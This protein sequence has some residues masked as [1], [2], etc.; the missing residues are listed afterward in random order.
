MT[1]L[2]LF[3]Y[4]TPPFKEENGRKTEEEE[5][6]EGEEEEEGE[7]V[8]GEEEEEG[9][10]EGEEEEGEKEGEEGEEMIE[11][12]DVFKTV[13]YNFSFL[14]NVITFPS[15]KPVIFSNNELNIL[16][17]TVLLLFELLIA[18]IFLPSYFI[19]LSFNKVTFGPK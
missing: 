3:K 9:G 15:S 4:I 17:T 16:I 7:D 6:D 1:R 8:E 18:F 13:R 11:R 10:E 2:I 19:I 12:N 5:E 14:I